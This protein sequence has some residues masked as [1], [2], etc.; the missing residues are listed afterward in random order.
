MLAC[1][2][3]MYASTSISPFVARTV[4]RTATS[5]FFSR[6]NPRTTRS[7]LTSRARARLCRCPT[8]IRIY[9]PRCGTDGVTYSHSCEL[10][11]MKCILPMRKRAYGGGC[12]PC[13]NQKCA[14]FQ[15]CK[16]G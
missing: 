4:S 16:F 5:A 11:N 14:T 9:D 7:H 13:K 8:A 6:H 12:D 15:E 10:E 3:P 2:A 1:A